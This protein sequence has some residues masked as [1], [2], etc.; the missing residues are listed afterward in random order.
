MTSQKPPRREQP[1]K[2]KRNEEEF[3]LDR[4]RAKTLLRD[5]RTPVQPGNTDL[6]NMKVTISIWLDGDII[7]FFKQRAAVPGAAP[8]QTQINDALRSVMMLATK[9]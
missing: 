1:K 4:D 5:R 8:Y 2:T 3:P 7:E 6:Q 9:K